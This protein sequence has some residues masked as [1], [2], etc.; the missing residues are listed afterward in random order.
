MVALVGMVVVPI[1][2]LLYYTSQGIPWLLGWAS[3]PYDPRW[4]NQYPRRAAWMALA[5]PAIL[6]GS[7]SIAHI[8]EQQ[9]GSIWSVGAQP[10][11]FVLAIIGLIGKLKRAPLDIPKA[12]SEISAGPLT[13]FSGRKLAIWNPWPGK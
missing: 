10:V 9:S 2:S 1:I 6:N 7:W 13:E 3:A 5:G 12:K 8:V 11:G 4:A